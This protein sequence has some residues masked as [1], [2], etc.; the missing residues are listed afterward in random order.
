MP[1][2]TRV[3]KELSS[4]GTHKHIQGVCSADNAYYSRA[5]VVAGIDR[6]ELWETSGGGRRARVKKIQYCPHGTCDLSPY[7][8]RAPDHTTENNLDN[9]PLC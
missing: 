4:D 1:T 5:Q 3:R 9:L 2:V 7:I 6:G 8:T